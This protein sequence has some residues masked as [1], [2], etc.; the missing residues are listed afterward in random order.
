[1]DDS[2]FTIQESLKGVL[3]NFP[4]PGFGRLLRWLVFPFGSPYCK[5]S[6]RTLSEAAEL[7]LTE[8]ESRDRLVSG[9]YISDLE[10]AAG[11]VHTAF[12]L[13]LT[14]TQDA[15][16]VVAGLTG[17]LAVTTAKIPCRNLLEGPT[18]H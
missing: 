2:L 11:R 7:L 4:I 13:V 12:H 8:N 15:P 17:D 3:R 5:P 16:P 14:A 18:E 10:D 6:D 1:M 9:V